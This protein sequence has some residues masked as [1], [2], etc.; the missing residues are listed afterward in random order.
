MME[1]YSSNIRSG[2]NFLGILNDLK[3]RP[4]DAA[5]E[6]QVSL[7]EIT[8][9]IKGEKELPFDI[10]KRAT[11]IWSINIG[12]FFLIKD[13]CPDGIKIMRV[14]DSEKSSRT[15]DRAGFPYYEYRDTAMSSVS[16]FRPEWI[17][18]LCIVDDNKPDNPKVQWNNGHFMHQFTYFIGEVNYYYQD[19][20]G[21]KRVAVMNTGDSV[22]GTPF[23][24]HSFATRKGASKNGLILAL[25]YGNTLLTSQQELSALGVE[26]G[27]NFYLDF[28]SKENAFSSLL[29]FH[30]DNA[31]LSL[32]EVSKRS[33]LSKEILENLET[34]ISE[35]PDDD[36]IKKIAESLNV[37]LR[38]LYP[39]DVIEEKVIVR[40]HKDAPSWLYPE[41]GAYKIIELAKSRHLP[42]SKALEFTI[43]KT[44][45]EENLDLKMGLHQYIYNVGES[46]VDF[47]W[48]INNNMHHEKLNPGDSMYVKPFVNHNFRGNGKL[49][50]LR[51][52]GRV[53]GDGQREL[54]ILEKADAHRA[55][56]ETSMWFDPSGK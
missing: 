44:D 52:A 34:N 2:I 51:I 1:N 6:L 28:S 50:V 5:E 47:R 21:T 13:D 25:T 12:D 33:G 17:E 32:D 8:S 38:D 45:D 43:Q 20:D 4:E 24:P 40:T 3:R 7:E 11:E 19:S 41:S 31:S 48:E 23:R 55:I 22:Y 46:T 26:L 49:M 29:K 39:P 9:I 54:S 16:L 15:M 18:E 30:R 36:M 37:N 27:L 10:I 14:G 53:A 35:L 56:L 42:F